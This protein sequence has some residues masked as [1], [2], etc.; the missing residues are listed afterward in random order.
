MFLA[1]RHSLKL[2]SLFV[3]CIFNC[4][5]NHGIFN[6]CAVS[7]LSALP[8]LVYDR[9]TLLNIRLRADGKMHQTLP[10]ASGIPTPLLAS[11]PAYLRRV[12]S[13]PLGKKRRKRRGRRGG[14]A[15]KLKLTLGRNQRSYVL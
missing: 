4:I 12:Q 10:G 8:V 14:F 11:V 1:C 2:L 15:V 7:S 13:L 5:L 3:L 9:Q 6:L